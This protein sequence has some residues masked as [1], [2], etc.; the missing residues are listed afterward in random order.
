MRVVTVPYTPAEGLTRL[1]S[2]TKTGAVMEAAP[3]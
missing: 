1:S 2:S 3:L